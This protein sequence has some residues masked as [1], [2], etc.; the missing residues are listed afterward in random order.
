MGYSAESEFRAGLYGG[1]KLVQD[2]PMRFQ[3]QVEINKQTKQEF[4]IEVTVRS[5]EVCDIWRGLPPD[6]C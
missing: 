5:D 4:L 6:R 1:S 2:P 3:F